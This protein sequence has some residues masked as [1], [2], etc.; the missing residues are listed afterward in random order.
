MEKRLAGIRLAEVRVE[1]FILFIGVRV[2]ERLRFGGEFFR[3]TVEKVGKPDIDDV[4]QGGGG[5]LQVILGGLRRRG[6]GRGFLGRNQGAKTEKHRAEQRNCGDANATNRRKYFCLNLT[7]R[8]P[9]FFRPAS[10]VKTKIYL[11]TVISQVKTD[12][13]R[14]LKFSLPGKSRRSE[15]GRNSPGARLTC[16][17]RDTILDG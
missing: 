15:P 11:L 16:P 14:S 3:V 13:I 10:G 9:S 1:K 4:V 12:S 7:H 17:G 5:V 6:R 2:Q 8:F